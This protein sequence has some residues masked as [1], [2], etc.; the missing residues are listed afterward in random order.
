MYINKKKQGQVLINHAKE[1]KSQG[2]EEATLFSS[3]AFYL[4]NLKEEG[5]DV[6]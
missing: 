2:N 4:K 5:N 1:T 6:I 3:F